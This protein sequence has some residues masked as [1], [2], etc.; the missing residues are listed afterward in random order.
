MHAEPVTFGLKVAVWYAEMERQR[1]R[2]LWARETIAVG[3]I[4]GAVGTFAHIPPS[5]ERYVCRKLGLKPAPAATQ[6]L[7]RDRLAFYLGVL[8]GIGG[9]L[10]KFAT[11]I[12]NLQRTEVLEVEEFFAKGQ[13]GSSAMPHKRNPLTCERVAGLS[14]LLRGYAVAAF[15]NQALWHER[16]LTHSS[17]ERVILPD[18]T[19]VLHY[20]LRKFSEVMEH[21]RVYPRHMERN[22]W[23]TKGLVVSQQVLLA[24]VEKGLLREKAYAVVQRNALEAWEKEKDFYELLKNDPEVRKHLSADELRAL[25]DLSRHRKFVPFLLKRTGVL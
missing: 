2:L 10:E 19:I 24:L 21:L 1:Q 13:K 3:K 4:S 25:F 17:V 18:A 22:L 6:V 15:E 5:I 7:Q 12:R 14:R 8:A 16:D 20:M 11:E 9:S 23:R